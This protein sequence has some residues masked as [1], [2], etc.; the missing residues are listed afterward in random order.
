[1][2]P[3]LCSY[4]VHRAEPSV[5]IY[6]R[7][8][9]RL[10][11]TNSFS[12]GLYPERSRVSTERSRVYPE[13]SRVSTERSRVSTERSRG[14]V[15]IYNGF[16]SRLRSTISL[17]RALHPEQRVF[18]FINFVESFRII[19]IHHHGKKQNNRNRNRCN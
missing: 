6:S 15:H 7:F 16:S 17:S 9:S 12:R 1:M 10:R 14:G 3:R 13:R 11:S 8:S 5:H 4:T 18:Q 19:F 2:T